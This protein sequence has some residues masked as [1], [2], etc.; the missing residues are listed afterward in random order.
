MRVKICPKCKEINDD[1]AFLCIKCN[2]S[3]DLVRAVELPETGWEKPPAEAGAGA[4]E[5]AAA[6]ETAGT[7]E[8]YVEC[9][10]CAGFVK[11]ISDDAV[12]G[13]G[14]DID[15]TALDPGLLISRRHAV[16]TKK[17]GR[18]WIE[19]LSANNPS[20]LN[21]IPLDLG[22]KYVVSDGD[23]LTLADKDFVLRINS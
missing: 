12:I 19:H 4:G 10:S 17:D 7:G 5:T 11:R 18:W 16:F 22:R 8:L 13:R 3:L 23:R 20:K 1:I 9:V 2:E 15:V 6:G 21:Y 14:A